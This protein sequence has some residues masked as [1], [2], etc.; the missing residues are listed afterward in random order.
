MSDSYNMLTNATKQ[1]QTLRQWT[2]QVQQLAAA[3][4]KSTKPKLISRNTFSDP[5]TNTPRTQEAYEL[6][7]EAVT[8]NVTCTSTQ[9]NGGP[10]AAFN[11]TPKAPG[12]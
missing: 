12:S 6:T 7:Y 1:G 8:Y 3:F 9:G 5:V 4:G 11:S 2:V 10:I